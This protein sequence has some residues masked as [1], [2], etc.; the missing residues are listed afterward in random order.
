VDFQALFPK[1]LLRDIKRWAQKTLRGTKVNFQGT[2]MTRRRNASLSVIFLPLSGCGTF[3][4]EIYLF[5]GEGSQIMT[6]NS[7]TNESSSLRAPSEGRK[8]VIKDRGFECLF[9]SYGEKPTLFSI[10]K[11]TKASLRCIRIT[12]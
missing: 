6:V 12:N 3:N 8:G 5:I 9:E 2:L 10:K 7:D 1:K 11:H 4:D